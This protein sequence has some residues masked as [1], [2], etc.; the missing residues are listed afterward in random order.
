MLVKYVTRQLKGDLSISGSLSFVS[1]FTPGSLHLPCSC[2]SRT[3]HF[4]QSHV[5]HTGMRQR[6][7][8]TYCNV[9]QLTNSIDNSSRI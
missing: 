8:V 6:I 5:R 3:R 2:F 9:G 4:S 1:T 7:L